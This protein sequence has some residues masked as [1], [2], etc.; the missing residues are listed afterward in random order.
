MKFQILGSFE[1]VRTA[2]TID[3]H[4]SKRRRV[5]VYQVIR[6]GQSMNRDRLVQDMWGDSGSAGAPWTKQTYVS[7]L[8]ML[9]DGGTASNPGGSSSASSSTG[10]S[11]MKRR[12]TT[13]GATR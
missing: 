8:R 6:A 3:L 4:G 7:Q 9:L 11:T 1:V 5:L 10:S 12:S 13:P 2:G